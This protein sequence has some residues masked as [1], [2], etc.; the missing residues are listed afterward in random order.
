[1]EG[2]CVSETKL[3]PPTFLKAL[4]LLSLLLVACGSDPKSQFLNNPEQKSIYIASGACYGGGVTLSTGSGTIVKYNLETKVMTLIK[5]YQASASADFPAGLDNYNS[6]QLVALVENAAGR[7]V[8]LVN[9]SGGSSTWFTN[10]T[11]LAS[12]TRGIKVLRDGGVLIPETTGIEKFNSSGG[13]Q[14]APFITNPGGTCATVNTL[15]VASDELPNGKILL[16]HAA[17]TTNNKTA[18]IS[19]TGYA[20]VADC[21]TAVTAPITTALPTAALYH[22]NTNKLLISSGSTTLGSNL[23]NAYDININTNVIS[24]VTTAFLN[25][26]IVNGPSVMVED[27]STGTVYVAN[28]TNT[29]NNVEAFSFNSATKFLSRIGT[30]PIVPQSVYTRCISGMVVE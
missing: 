7:R 1:M 20:V 16:V 30:T 22:T 10:S 29:F 17:A 8:E 14:G 2:N 15:V 23:I 25:E 5:D 21:L 4:V 12:V 24:G 26:S 6:A 28:A 3:F 18:L 19:A 13:R 11:A 27:K 9:K